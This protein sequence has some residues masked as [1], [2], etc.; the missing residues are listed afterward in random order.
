MYGKISGMQ[1]VF[2]FFFPQTLSS[3]LFLC[4]WRIGG[5]VS[6]KYD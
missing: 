3:V 2:I 5:V 4:H 1:C 6:L